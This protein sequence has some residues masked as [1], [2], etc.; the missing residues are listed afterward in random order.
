MMAIIL[1]KGTAAAHYIMA[2]PQANNNNAFT[3]GCATT[4][5]YVMH[6]E[7]AAVASFARRLVKE[8][9]AGKPL[10]PVIK[11][12]NKTVQEYVNKSRPAYCAKTGMVDEVVAFKDLRKYLVAFANCCYQNPVSI[13]PQHQMILPRIIKG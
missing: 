8:K 9:D 10:E 6:G 13:T 4:E 11:S 3:L 7:T 12:M 2:G 5:I 1:R